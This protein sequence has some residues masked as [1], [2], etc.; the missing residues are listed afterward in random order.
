MHRIHS[1]RSLLRL[2]IH[3]SPQSLFERYITTRLVPSTVKYEFLEDV[4]RLDYYVPGGY[5]PVTLGDEFCSGRYVIAHKLG[6]GRS[7]TTWLAEDTHQRRL[8]ALKISTAESAYRN[9]E[10]KVLSHLGKAESNLPGK[11]LVQKLLDAF[12]ISGPNGTHQCLVTDAARLNIN[13]VKEYPY[14][15]LLPLSVA[16]AIAAQLVLGVQFTHSQGIVHGGTSE[17]PQSLSH[18]NTQTDLHSA[19]IL[20]QLPPDMKNMTLEQLRGRTGEP[21]MEAVVREDGAPLDPGVPPELVIPIWL[22][23]DSDK[24]T[25][26]DASIMIADFGEGFDPRESKQYTA[27]TPLLLAPPE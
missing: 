15:R 7:A 5:H 22:G 9:H 16:R 6:F 12:T 8:V 14:H 2:Y 4:E 24:V 26:G 10:L 11:A 20:L 23:I 17:V 18:T 27:H 19:N 1:P 21:A 25:L 13:E 3:C